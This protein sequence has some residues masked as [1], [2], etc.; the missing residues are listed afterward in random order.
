[1]KLHYTAGAMTAIGQEHISKAEWQR[2]L[3]KEMSRETLTLSRTPED[4]PFVKLMISFYFKGS[5]HDQGIEFA[6]KS[7]REYLFAEHI[8]E[9]LKKLSAGLSPDMPRRAKHWLNFPRSDARHKLAQMLG[10]LFAPQ[11]MSREVCHHLEDLLRWEIARAHTQADQQPST[12][13]TRF[14]LQTDK[15]A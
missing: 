13:V 14:G 5:H 11:W 3:P 4:D 10:E 7:F 12:F 15:A 2:R 9:T 1:R 6:H 8:V